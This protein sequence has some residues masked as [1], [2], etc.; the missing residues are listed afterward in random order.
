MTPSC[1][2]CGNGA[3]V[4]T[5][6][7]TPPLTT[8]GSEQWKEY[9]KQSQTGKPAND[10]PSITTATATSN[11]NVKITTWNSSTTCEQ[12]CENC[13]KYGQSCFDGIETTSSK[14]IISH[15][16]PLETYYEYDFLDSFIK[17][18]QD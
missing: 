16:K 18:F 8:S 3:I 4:T 17:H 1:F 9:L 10:N 2:H 5:D 14:A 13:D 11:P 7:T 15:R 12:N 6:K